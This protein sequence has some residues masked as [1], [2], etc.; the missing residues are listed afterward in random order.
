MVAVMNGEKLQ[1]KPSC[2]QDL[3]D[4]FLRAKEVIDIAANL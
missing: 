2:F 4:I 3:L 1:L